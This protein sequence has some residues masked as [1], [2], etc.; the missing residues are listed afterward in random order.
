MND[1]LV[2]NTRMFAA[3]DGDGM[4]LRSVDDFSPADMLYIHPEVV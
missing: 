4:A 1:L 2:F 3:S